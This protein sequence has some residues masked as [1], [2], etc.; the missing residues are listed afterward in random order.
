MNVHR[1]PLTAFNAFGVLGI[2]ILLLVAFYYQIAH[3]EPPCPL[4]LLQRA[5]FVVIGMGFLFNLRV[6]ERASHYAMVL[7]G[8]LITGFYALRQV[9]LNIAPDSTGYGSTLLGL[10]FYTW[11][12]IASACAVTYVALLLVAKDVLPRRSIEV[13]QSVSNTLFSLF[14]LL[15]AANLISTILV[16]GLTG[17]LANPVRYLL[18]G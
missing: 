4:C 5:G 12:L 9:M 1:S 15:C 10:H 8:A 16:C 13:S 7:A 6:G 17:C 3:A 11:A 18:P 14:A 2:S